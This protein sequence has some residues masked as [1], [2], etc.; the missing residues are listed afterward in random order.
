[1]KIFFLWIFLSF[2][3]FKKLEH[4]F[5]LGTNSKSLYNR[6]KISANCDC[7]LPKNKKV[8]ITCY[9]VEYALQSVDYTGL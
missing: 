4:V 7:L 1:M 9:S 3:R 2:S 6:L 5:N 8:M